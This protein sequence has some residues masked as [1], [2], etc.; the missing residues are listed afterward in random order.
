MDSGNFGVK[1]ALEALILALRADQTYFLASDTSKVEK[2]D[3]YD[4]N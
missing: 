3:V 1:K 2:F 4:F